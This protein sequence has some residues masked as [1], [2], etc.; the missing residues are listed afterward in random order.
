MIPEIEGEG[1]ACVLYGDRLQA[2]RFC[3]L[4][5]PESLYTLMPHYVY[6]HEFQVV[7]DY[8]YEGVRCVELD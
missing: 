3:S 2:C 6:V 5:L 8:V 7:A 4:S 1:P